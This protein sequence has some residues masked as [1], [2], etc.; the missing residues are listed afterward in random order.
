MIRA[1]K[2]R[3]YPSGEQD[4]LMRKHLWLE[5]EL[6]NEML[7]HTKRMY[8]DF[9]RFPTKVGLRE[10]VKGSGL[11]SQVGQELVDR[12]FD[13]LGGKMRRKKRGLCGGFP[14]FKSFDRVKS[15]QYPQSGFRLGETLR[16]SPFGEIGIVR[17]REIKGVVK[18]L[19]LKREASGKWFAVFTAEQEVVPKHNSGVA[20][21]LDLGLKN[22]AVLSDGIVI[23]NPRHLRKHEEKL[24][25]LQRRLSRKVKRGQNWYKAKHKVALLHER[26]ANSRKDFLHKT[27]ASLVSQYSLIALEDLAPK[28]MAEQ[29]YGKSIHDV[30]WGMFAGM[31]RYKAVSAGCE[32]VF[33][34]PKNTTK[35]CSRCGFLSKKDLRDR[36]H[37][38]PSCGYRADRD[39]NAAETILKRATAGQAESNAYGLVAKAT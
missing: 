11:Y 38:C 12:L 37:D 22:F 25:F 5:K 28:K 8:V 34:N 4:V 39:L 26:V 9:G 13:A 30:G 1:Y 6:W 14:R 36:I 10:F 33:V 23:S 21:G 24:A 7:E 20:V 27:S 35:E 31:V 2:F 29:D 16:V 3:L 17:H 18:T 32:A 15:L 19:A